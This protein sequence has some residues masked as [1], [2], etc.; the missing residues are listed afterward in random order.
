MIPDSYHL[1]EAD[2]NRIVNEAGAANDLADAAKDLLAAHY[3]I[4][5]LRHRLRQ[6]GISL[7]TQGV[8]MAL[9]LADIDRELK[10]NR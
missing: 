9:A 5:G 8:A 3:E 7:A 2:L 6:I 10:E 1:K 4:E